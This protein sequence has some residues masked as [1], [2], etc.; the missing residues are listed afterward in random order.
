MTSEEKVFLEIKFLM[1]IEKWR[2]KLTMA[3]RWSL[4]E[5]KIRP[6]MDKQVAMLT[7]VSAITDFSPM[8]SANETIKTV[9][10]KILTCRQCS[11]S[12]TVGFDFS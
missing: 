2:R 4:G 9:G 5:T 6:L 12:S 11:S 8:K 1:E 10:Q 7:S 3:S